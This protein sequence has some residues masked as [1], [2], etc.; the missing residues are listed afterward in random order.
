MDDNGLDKVLWHDDLGS[1]IPAILFS[2]LSIKYFLQNKTE[3]HRMGNRRY[4]FLIGLGLISE[5][6][7][8]ENQKAVKKILR[9][10]AITTS[11]TF[12]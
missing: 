6:A 11:D 8:Q 9:E 10:V 5:S 4:S 1:L 2:L 7:W 12:M 3:K